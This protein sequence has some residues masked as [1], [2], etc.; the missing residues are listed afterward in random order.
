MVLTRPTSKLRR[1]SFIEFRKYMDIP[2][3]RLRIEEVKK[4]LFQEHLDK[5]GGD[6]H[7]YTLYCAVTGDTSTAMKSGE[8]VKLLQVWEKRI[9]EVEEKMKAA[10]EECKCSFAQQAELDIGKQL[11]SWKDK[12]A[13]EITDV[14]MK[15]LKQKF[16]WVSWSVRVYPHSVSFF[17]NFITGKKHEGISGRNYFAFATEPRVVVSYS[18]NPAALDKE[19]LRTFVGNRKR[20]RNKAKLAQQLQALHPRCMVHAIGRDMEEKSNFPDT[21]RFYQLHKG[22]HI[23]V[24][25]DLISSRTKDFFLQEAQQSGCLGD[26]SNGLQTPNCWS[27]FHSA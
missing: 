12:S 21:A 17:R 13:S 22:T 6:K 5:T 10:V 23:F 4:K 9:M 11:T 16:D 26:S 8:E 15:F 20:M 24:Y 7:L 27:P 2:E 25:S 3:L 14:I 19:T 1:T 18:L